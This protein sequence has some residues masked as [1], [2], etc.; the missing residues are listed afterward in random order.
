MYEIEIER[1]DHEGRGIGYINGKVTFVKNALLKE[2]V[3]CEILEEKKNYNIAK[4][5]HYKKISEKRVKPFC[6]YYEIC[7]GCNL[8]HMPYDETIQYKEEKVKNILAKEKIDFPEIEI[9]ENPSPTNYRNKLS[10]KIKNGKIGFFEEN[11]HKLIEIKSC[12]LAK[13]CINH[14]LK[15]IKKLKIKNGKVTIRANYNEEVLLIIETEEKIHWNRDDF[16]NIKIVGVILNNK[17][18]YGN[19]YFYEPICNK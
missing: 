3:E 19:Y 1:I 8:E 6:S 5:I 7:G 9:I 15:N 18:I 12:P 17:I 11:T 14:C 10:L 13:S 2:V 16:E 4:I